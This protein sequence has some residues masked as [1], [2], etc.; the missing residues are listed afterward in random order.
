MSFE[1]EP[2]T[3]SSRIIVKGRLAHDNGHERVTAFP[4][5]ADVGGSKSNV[6][7]WAS[8]MSYGKRYCTIA[9]LNLTSEAMADADT[10]GNAVPAKTLAGATAKQTIVDDLH[11]DEKPKGLTLEQS[12][13]LVALIKSSG[14]GL[15]KFLDKYQIKAVIDLNPSL[16]D[17][18]V[19]AC[20]NYAREV[21][22]KTAK[23]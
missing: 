3:D 9:L 16:Y 20:N 6:Q 17:R 21:K 7:A 23:S 18:A 11:D 4:L 22:S 19:D 15:E 2:S 8:S 12:T 13:K 1:K 10:D 14:V 5:P